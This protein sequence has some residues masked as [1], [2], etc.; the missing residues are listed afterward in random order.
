MSQTGLAVF[1]STLHTTNTWLNDVMDR[2]GC[3]D[4]QRA[5]HALRAVLHA[6]RNRLP[7]EA[8]AGLGAQLP[9]LVRGL[10]YEG[11][12]PGGK[13]VKERKKEEFLAHIAA[14]FRHDPATTAADVARAVFRVLA[15]HVT[16]GEVAKV[17]QLLPA[18]IRE[19][20]SEEERS[21]WM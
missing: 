2:L 15:R 12:H 7:V 11:W 8:V 17:S 6:L 14:E 3:P 5:Y 21:L 19:L 4:R 10:Y 20:W 16:A 18:E 13:P 1:D 9:L